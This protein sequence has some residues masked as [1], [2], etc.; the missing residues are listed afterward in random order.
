MS[1]VHLQ[2]SQRHALRSDGVEIG[3]GACVLR[4]A[5][6]AHPV[7]GLAARRR[8]L[9]GWLG[10]VA[11]AEPRDLEALQGFVGDIGHVDVEQDGLA[12]RSLLEALD[13][14]ARD[15]RRG[16]V[17][18]PRLAGERDRERRDPEQVALGRRRDRSRVD[19]IVAHV[20]PEI[21][22]R[23]DD[24]RHLIEQA[25]DRQMYAVGGRAVHKAEP[26]RRFAHGQGPVEGE[27]IRRAAE[28]ALRC[29]YGNASQV[30]EGGCENGE[31]GCE[32]PVVVAQ[33][34]PHLLNSLIYKDNLF[35]PR[36]EAR[37]PGSG[38]FYSMLK[39][40]RARRATEPVARA[41]AD[42]GFRTQAGPETGPEKRT[43][44][45]FP[46]PWRAS[47]DQRIPRG[48][49]LRSRLS[50]LAGTARGNYP[51]RGLPARRLRRWHRR[52]SPLPCP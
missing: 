26:V 16:L 31:P 40:E 1:Q 7:H 9:D 17:V 51:L 22:A 50:P 41:S 20:G 25:G 39:A 42:V 35:H 5:G 34:D 8:G 15:P 30:C 28:V 37:R 47:S 13:Q 14:V 48:T 2:R 44:R 43:A 27:G 3:S 38:G 46:A 23:Y 49:P 10:L 11:P 45:L 18:P 21:D 36:P 6:R 29:D 52:H 33:Q 4:A 32:I 19:R 24:V 12:Q